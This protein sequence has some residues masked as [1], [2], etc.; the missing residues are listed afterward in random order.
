M[1]SHLNNTLYRQASL[2]HLNSSSDIGPALKV[3]N[4][5]EIL[6]LFVAC[7]AIAGFLIWGC[8]G[9]ISLDINSQG[10]L[11]PAEKILKIDQEINLTRKA[12]IEK[13]ALLEKLY[14]D[15]KSMYKKHLLTIDALMKASDDYIIAKE[16][17]N[18]SYKVLDLLSGENADSS[19][20]E[21]DVLTFVDHYQGKKISQGMQAYVLPN[22]LSPY[23]YGY[24]EAEVVSISQYPISKELAFS[25]LG[26]MNLVDDFF[27]NGAPYVVKLHLKQNKKLP[28]GLAWTTK[29]GPFF[30][31]QAGSLVNTKIIYKKTKPIHLI[32][33]S[34]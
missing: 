31:I 8:F 4:R 2:K 11:M 18:Q 9:E 12:R 15:K 1:S 17:I 6:L 23:E 34:N 5:T 20:T 3:I 27:L 29:R 26:N 7:L 19:N 16:A 24:I 25:Y 33:K 30:S 10:V 21:L 14:N 28:S 32:S 22:T 13:A